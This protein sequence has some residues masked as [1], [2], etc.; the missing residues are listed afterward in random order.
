M[1]MILDLT[2]MIFGRLIVVKRRDN[3]KDD[4]RRWIC[5]CRCGRKSLVMTSNLKSGHTQSCGCLREDRLISKLTTHGLSKS[6]E[7][8]TWCRMKDRCSNPKNIGYINYGGRG[9]RVCSEWLDSFEIFISNMGMRPSK[10]YTIDRIDNDGNYE[11]SNCRWAT[12]SEQSHNRRT[13]R[14]NTSGIKGV[15]KIKKNKYR[16]LIM[17]NRKSHHLGYFNTLGEATK[18]RKGAEIEFKEILC[19]K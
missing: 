10:K 12:R 2:G 13:S 8:I 7:Y 16:A 3:T 18:A 17:F 19:E 6:S 5:L 9:I 14:N 11:A 15:Y 4:S 1:S